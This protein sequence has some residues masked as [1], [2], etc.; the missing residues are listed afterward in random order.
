MLLLTKCLILERIP[1]FL[2]T[3]LPSSCKCDFQFRLVSIM[4]PRYLA[5]LFNEI[6]RNSKIH[7]VSNF[8]LWGMKYHKTSLF[9][10]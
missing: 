10:I 9:N 2:A 7:L 6:I 5:I 3:F 1:M 4:R 8:P